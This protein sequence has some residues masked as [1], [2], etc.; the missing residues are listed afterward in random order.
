MVPHGLS[1]KC[2]GLF[3]LFQLFQCFPHRALTVMRPSPATTG[4]V[5]ACVIA[6]GA[7]THLIHL[8]RGLVGMIEEWARQGVRTGGSDLPPCRV[9]L[10]AVKHHQ[11]VLLG[12]SVNSGLSPTSQRPSDLTEDAGELSSGRSRNRESIHARG[13]F[14]A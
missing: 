3:F 13:A 2:A 6:L 11:E 5:L 9:L 14:L 12:R 1:P 10:L 7:C 4:D 8:L